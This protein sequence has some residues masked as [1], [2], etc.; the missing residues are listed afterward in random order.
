MLTPQSDTGELAR[1]VKRYLPGFCSQIKYGLGF[2][3]CGQDEDFM[4]LHPG[5]N[6]PGY[7]SLLV[8]MPG[9]EQGISIMIN[10][11]NGNDLIL[12][13]FYSFAQVYKWIRN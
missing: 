6:L 11:E 2:I 5:H 4:F 3:L 10:G 13:I 7:R 9:K 12:E 1:E 8:I